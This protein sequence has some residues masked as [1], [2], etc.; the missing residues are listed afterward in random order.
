MNWRIACEE[1]H[2]LTVHTL[3]VLEDGNHIAGAGRLYQ[4]ILFCSGPQLPLHGNSIILQTAREWTEYREG[5]SME[6]VFSR[7][8]NVLTIATVAHHGSQAQQVWC[9]TVRC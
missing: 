7:P 6:L 2:Q 4:S 5:P 1:K 3:H 9:S 8:K